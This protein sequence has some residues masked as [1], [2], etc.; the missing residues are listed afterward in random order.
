MPVAVY[1]SRVMLFIVSTLS[2]QLGRT[3]S[4]PINPEGLS[5]VILPTLFHSGLPTVLGVASEA[6]RS[7]TFVKTRVQSSVVLV[8]PLPA[9]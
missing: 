6:C 7:K 1:T 2:P 4:K 3:Q 9:W 5:H 8:L